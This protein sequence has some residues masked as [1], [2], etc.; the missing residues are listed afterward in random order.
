[1]IHNLAVDFLGLLIMILFTISLV[2]EHINPVD[3]V[4]K[5][6]NLV[7]DLPVWLS[8][9]LNIIGMSGVVQQFSVS[10]QS[11]KNIYVKWSE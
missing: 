10:N 4:M 6:K 2:W 8:N 5:P 1:M 7:M 11:L 9:T 3:P